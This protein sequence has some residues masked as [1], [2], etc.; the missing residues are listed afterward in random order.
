MKKGG[1]RSVLN[2]RITGEMR[3]A[4]KAEAERTGRSLSAV[5]ELWLE[6]AHR[7]ETGRLIAGDE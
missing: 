4:L 1:K 2:A 7:L 6:I 3:A 5:A